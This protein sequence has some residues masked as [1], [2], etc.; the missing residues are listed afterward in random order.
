MSTNSAE[1]IKFTS[2]QKLVILIL[3]LTQF[4][5]VLDFMVMSPLGDLLMKSMKITPSQFGIVVSSYAF[6]AGISGFLTAGFADKFDR[7]KLLLF[8]Y[9]GFIV[10]TLLCGLV[11]SYPLL[12]AARIVTGIFGGVISSIS[13]AIVADL[14]QFNQRGRVMG[15]LQ[16]GFGISQILGIPISLY[17]ANKWGWQ[18]PFFM[19]V[20]LAMLISM[21]GIIFLKPVK[22]HLALQKDNA[23]V[24]LWKTIKNRDYRIAYLATAFLS[25]GG[26][27]MMPWGS[28]FSVNNLGISQEQLPI[29]FMIAGI[30]TLAI[31]PIIGIISDKIN[32]FTLFTIA[33]LWMIVTV[34][35]YTHLVPM[36]FWIIVSVNVLMMIG[37]MARMVPSQALTASV[38]QMKD[39]G[40][41]MS[42]NS[43]LQQ[44]AGGFAAVLGGMIVIQKDNNSPL[45]RFDIL[46]YTVLVAILT[47]IFLTYRVNKMVERNLKKNL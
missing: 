34:L 28:T 10:G 3:A 32:K 42:V 31:M 15:F 1:K 39:R 46:G 14:F 5:V 41:F 36:P 18:S 20:G 47:N 40:A 38:P 22:E 29:L 30:S 8:F 23:L 19:I 4:T 27:L 35:I 11:T 7:K 9:I 13:M 16:M 43:S 24:H 45:E 37:I 44:M 12:V 26:F 21:V 6:S 17:F 2:Y 25:M 33:S